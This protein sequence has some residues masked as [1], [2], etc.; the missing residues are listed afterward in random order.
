MLINTTCKI[1]SP[2]DNLPSSS[3]APPAIIL[4]TK[5]PSSSST[6]WFPT[7]PAILKPR[8]VQKN[9]NNVSLSRIIFH[10]APLLFFIKIISIQEVGDEGSLDTGDTPPWPIFTVKN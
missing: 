10:I 6:C 7:P 4:V 1:L 9:Q 3:A 8:P 5:I 2:T